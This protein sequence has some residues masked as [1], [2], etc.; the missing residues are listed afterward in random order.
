M[1]KTLLLFVLT[2]ISNSLLAQTKIPVDSVN[3][4][5]REN[6]IICTQVFGVKSTATISFINLGAAYPNAPLTV[7]VFAKDSA[8]FKE[9]LAALYDSKKICVTGIL[10]VY[11]GKT[12]IVVTKPEHIEV[13]L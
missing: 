13:V 7:V 3:N 1:I 11:K 12:Q 2:I 4:H 10:N 5:I 6:V 9:P 8:N